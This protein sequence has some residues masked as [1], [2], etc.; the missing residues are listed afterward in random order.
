MDLGILIS[1]IITSTAALVA[2]IGG[3]LVSRVITLSGEKSAIQRKIWEVEKEIDIKKGMFESAKQEVEE[4]DIDDFFRYYAEDVLFNQKSVENILEEDQSI[5]LERDL[6]DSTVARMAEIFE[7][8]LKKIE[9][10]DD[11]YALPSEFNE[12]LRD[13]AIKIDED[14]SWHEHIYN[15][16][17]RHI[18]SKQSSFLNMDILSSVSDISNFKP[19]L[20]SQE[21][22]VKVRKVKNLEDDIKVL[23]ALRDAEEDMLKGY[24]K[25]SGLWGGLAVLIYACI[26]GIIIPSFLLPYPIGNYD[27]SATRMTLLVLF[28]SELIVLFAYLGFSM[29]RLTKHD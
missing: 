23:N 13:N 2:I 15:L 12:F 17:L 19:I 6:I 7:F 20:S 3:F 5:N 8:V 1:T 28:I 29:Y 16:I 9:D 4:E 25:I 26:A 21:Y 11:N 22:N 10:T 14:R 18:P 24:G 27:D